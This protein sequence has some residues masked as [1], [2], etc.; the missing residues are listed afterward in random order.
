MNSE[1]LW[2]ISESHTITR[3][4]SRTPPSLDAG[5]VDPVVWAVNEARLPN[6]LLPRECPRVAFHASPHSTAQDISLFFGD[7][8]NQYIIAVER[9]WLTR[10]AQC[11]LHCYEM[12]IS[13]F[14]YVDA[15]AGYFVSH[16]GVAPLRVETVDDVAHAV[17]AQNVT[18]RVEDR[19]HALAHAVSNSSLGFSCIR[20]RNALV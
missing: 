15:N 8:P 14:E 9:A 19:L 2:H 11:V 18:L 20:M 13:T 17:A 16:V 7:A 5:V 12:P 4:E 1:T 6:Y 10:I 3:F